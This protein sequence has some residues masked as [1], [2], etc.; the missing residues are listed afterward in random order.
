M[1]TNTGTAKYQA[2]E[3]LHGLF[4]HYEEAV[5]IWSAGA[6]IYYLL[7]GSHA[8]NYEMQREIEDAILKGEYG[9]T[10][11]YLNISDEAKELIGSMMRIDPRERLTAKEAMEHKWFEK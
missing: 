5:D 4:S 1:M 7:T 8:F 10:D 6:V 9:Q 3:M 11:E 2:P